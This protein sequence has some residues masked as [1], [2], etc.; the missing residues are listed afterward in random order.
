[1]EVADLSEPW[2][3]DE[4]LGGE[5]FGRLGESFVTG[6]SHSRFRLGVA[7]V[8]FHQGVDKGK[9]R[10]E[11]ENRTPA[12]E[13]GG[14]RIG[15]ASKVH[16]RVGVTPVDRAAKVRATTV[17]VQIGPVPGDVTEKDV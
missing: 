7:R 5:R 15:Q 11:V 8:R 10:R 1:E 9:V 13:T 4:Q 17:G 2:V 16:G 14:K 12:L 3:I 6:G